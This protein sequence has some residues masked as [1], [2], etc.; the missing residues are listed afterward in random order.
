MT[1]LDL[2]IRRFG[3]LVIGGALLLSACQSAPAPEKP[4]PGSGD[5]AFNTLSTF[6]LKDHYKRHPSTATDLGIHLYDSV[7][8][9]ASKQTIDNETAELTSF[10]QELEKID[11]AT[12]TSGR[13]LDREQL[14]HAMNSGI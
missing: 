10:R 13:Q 2:V 8:D 9:D 1:P 12:L 14:V 5:A 11:P 7:M 3:G 4:A 6:I